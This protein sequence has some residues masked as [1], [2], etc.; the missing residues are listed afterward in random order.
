MVIMLVGIVGIVGPPIAEAIVVN[1]GVVAL[2]ALLMLI[3]Q[4]KALHRQGRRGNDFF[5][6][7]YRD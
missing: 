5:R 1:L 6:L 3:R 7:P 4:R 2:A